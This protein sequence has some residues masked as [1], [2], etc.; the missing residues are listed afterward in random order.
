MLVV[1]HITDYIQQWVERVARIP[2]ESNG[3][4]PQVCVI[5]V[6]LN[7]FK[8]YVSLISIIVRRYYRRY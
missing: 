6:H 3:E 7:Y 5:E 2:V 1:P 8:V 4:A